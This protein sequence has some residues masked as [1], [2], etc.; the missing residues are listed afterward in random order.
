LA[1]YVIDVVQLGEVTSVS[2]F[3]VN[4]G[5]IS[6]IE[7]PFGGVKQSRRRTGGSK[8]GIEDFLEMKYLCI[9]L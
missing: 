9:S 4:T 2:R 1:R 8:Y 5:L 3:T 6:A 7:A